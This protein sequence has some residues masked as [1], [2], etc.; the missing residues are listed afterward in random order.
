MQH[1]KNALAISNHLGSDLECKVMEFCVGRC[2]T[3]T[4]DLFYSNIYLTLNNNY[5]PII[6]TA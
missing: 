3:K 5:R 4:F 1:K 2:F 6:N